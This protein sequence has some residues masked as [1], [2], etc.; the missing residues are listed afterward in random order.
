MDIV[1]TLNF[2][3][4]EFNKQKISYAIIGG[5]ALHTAGVPRA[6]SDIDFLIFSRYV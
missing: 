4:E 6:T 5:L 2:L 3:L 1:A